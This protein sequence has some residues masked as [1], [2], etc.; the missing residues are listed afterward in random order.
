MA[1]ELPRAGMQSDLRDRE[2]MR[3]V[4]QMLTDMELRII[5][6]MDAIDEKVVAS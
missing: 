6:E 1:I 2:H 4:E 5:R 3:L